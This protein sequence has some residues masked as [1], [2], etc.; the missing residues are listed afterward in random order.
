MSMTAYAVPSYSELE[1][2]DGRSSAVDRLS[3]EEWA[4]ISRDFN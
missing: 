4:V 1:V 3:P 2:D